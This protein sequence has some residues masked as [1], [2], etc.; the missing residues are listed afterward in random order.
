M[1]SIKYRSLVDYGQILAGQREGINLGLDGS[2]FVRKELTEGTFITPRI[3]TQGDSVGATG[4]SIDISAGTD[5]SIDIAVNGGAVVTATVSVAGLNTG[6]L[7]EAALEAAINA[8][9][10]ADGQDGRVWVNFDAGAPDQYTVTSQSTGLTSSVVITDAA[11]DN[12]ADDLGLGVANAGTETAGTDDQDFLLY[13]TGGPTFAQPVESNSH[14][15]GRFHSGVVKKK[16]VVEFDIDAMVNFSGAAG[17]SLDTAIRVLL[18]QTYGNETVVPGV[19]IDYTQGLPNFSF[20]LARVSTIFGEYYNGCYAKDYTLSIPGDDAATQKW[21][22]MGRTASIAGLAQ[23]DG[24]V[25]ASDTV[26][27]NSAPYNQ[28]ERYTVGARVMLVGTDGRTI[29]DGGDGSLTVLA[30]DLSLFTVQLSSVVDMDDNSYIVPWHPG[31]VQ[32]TGRDNIQTDLEGSIKLNPTSPA[33]CATSMTYSYGNDHVDLN[34]CFGQDSNV[35]FAAGQRVTATLEVTADLSGENIGDLIQARKFGGF[36][37]TIIIG[38]TAGRHR[39]LKFAKWIVDVPTIDLPENGTT[40]VTF[41]GTLYQSEPGARDP[42]T[43]KFK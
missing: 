28:A 40:P 17:D 15:S 1:G 29:T 19:S 43:D 21:T 24:A 31:A 23:V 41:S 34:N 7:I 10:A 2:I 22:G 27:V 3:G 36:N 14:R 5:D 11:S 12:V 18:E 13:T 33:I 16:K 8:A 25:V 4:S 9:L 37:P 20:S 26:T 30:T 6:A 42:I 39:E 38:D 32:Q 35:G